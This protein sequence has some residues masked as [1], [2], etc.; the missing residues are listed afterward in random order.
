MNSVD[1]SA[2]GLTVLTGT[3]FPG[4]SERVVSPQGMAASRK[5]WYWRNNAAPVDVTLECVVRAA[6][7]ATLVSYLDSIQYALNQDET[8]ALIVGAI[9]TD[10][11]WQAMYDGVPSPR[12]ILSATSIEWPIHFFADPYLENT[13]EVDDDGEMLT[14]PDDITIPAT[15]VYGGTANG[16]PTLIFRNTTGGVVAADAIEI[17]NA[18]LSQVL[19][20]GQD[21]ADDDYL[22]INTATRQAHVSS[23]LATWVDV[24][25]YITGTKEWIELKPLTS[26]TITTVGI[27]GTVNW[28]YRERYL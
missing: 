16:Q 28:T 2:Y 13:S 5:I 4:Y 22:R 17:H 23:D 27:T 6:D 24:S 26:N 15:G 25:E 3:P 20:Y 12:P 10:R 1:M 11:Q 9:Y 7:H 18:A 19:Y 21:L 14:D 8:K